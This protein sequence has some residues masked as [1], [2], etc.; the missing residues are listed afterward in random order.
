[1]VRNLSEKDES[2]LENIIKYCDS[3]ASHIREFGDSFES[4]ESNL[5]FQ[6]S[7]S[8]DAIQIG[9]AANKLTDEFKEAHPEI[10]WHQIVA[11][12]N[13]VAHA[14]GY[15]DIEILWETVIDDFPALREFCLNQLNGA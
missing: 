11:L 10:P 7:C 14:Y 15:I 6:E 5:A 8:F 1:M 12:R 13:S 2:A 4:F 9:E 3:A